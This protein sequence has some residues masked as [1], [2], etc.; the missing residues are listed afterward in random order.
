MTVPSDFSG[1]FS[2]D[3]RARFP[4]QIALIVLLRTVLVVVAV[5]IKPVDDRS[6]PLFDVFH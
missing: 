3:G 1:R 5:L 2:C 6:L 4:L